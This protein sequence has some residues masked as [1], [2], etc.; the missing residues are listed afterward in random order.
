MRLK[1]LLASGLFLLAPTLVLA[2]PVGSYTAQGVNSDGSKY[3]GKV[4]VT[5]TGETYSVTWKVGDGEFVGTGLGAKFV[6]DRFQMGPASADDTAISVGY[7]SGKTFGMAM[8]FQQPDGVW[9]GIWT[10][11]G[12]DKAAYENWVK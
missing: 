4:S 5:R 8:F 7:I 9:Q 3:E 1:M 11:G 2:D 10:F 12:S 6:G